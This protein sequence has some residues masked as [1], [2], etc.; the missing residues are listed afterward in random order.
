MIGFECDFCRMSQIDLVQG[1]GR[2]EIVRPSIM[3][4]NKSKSKVVIKFKYRCIDC[5]KKGVNTTPDDC[6]VHNSDNVVKAE[7]KIET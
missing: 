7:E 1:T 2:Q 4:R 5:I 6:T 3:V